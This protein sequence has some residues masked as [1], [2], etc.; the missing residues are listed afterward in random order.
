MRDQEVFCSR[1]GT[2]AVDAYS[3]GVECYENVQ[4]VILRKQIRGAGQ[5]VRV[6]Y[7]PLK[8][9]VDLNAS[10][11]EPPLPLSHRE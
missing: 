5:K 6:N 9:L 7:H 2:F 8:I 4:P 1:F 11:I 10:C 3:L